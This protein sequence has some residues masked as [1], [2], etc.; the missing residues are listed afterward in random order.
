MLRIHFTHEDLTRVRIARAPDPLAESMLSLSLVQ[1]REVGGVALEGWRSR[2]RRSIR[3]E[4]RV[5]FD[6]ATPVGAAEAAEALLHAGSH[7]LPESLEQ[8]WSLPGRRWTAEQPT[9]SG[10]RPRAP[11]WVHELHRGDREWREL[12]DRRLREYHAF[13]VAPYWSQLL[14]AAHTD[15]ARRATLVADLGLDGLFGSLHPGIRWQSPVLTLPSPVDADLRLRGAG[16]MLVPTFFW[17]EPLA[18]TDNRGLDHPLVLHYPLAPDLTTYREIWSQA[19]PDGPDSALV[20]LLGTTRARTL[21]AAADPAGTAELARRTGTSPATASHHTTVL[22]AA[23]LLTT[24][25]TGPR[26]RHTLTPLG[27]AL[28]DDRVPDGPRHKGDAPR[29]SGPPAPR[30][31]PTPRAVP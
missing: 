6:L 7:T 20:A 10:T 19:T 12:V 3:P 21:R 18:L 27:K 22:R 11:R 8:T 31:D 15:R 14:A 25:R 23:G 16:V 24:E 2:T 26:V 30:P 29:V 1:A 5:L 13:A 17:P 28:L 4:Q 9:L